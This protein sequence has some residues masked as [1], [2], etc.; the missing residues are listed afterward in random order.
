MSFLYTLRVASA[1][2]VI[3][4]MPGG[5]AS[6][7]CEAVIIMEMPRSFM[8]NRSHK[9]ELIA[10]A[11]R[12]IEFFLQKS[13]IISMSYSTPVEVSCMFTS[14]AVYVAPSYL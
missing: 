1:D 10:S 11:T 13:A 2:S 9:N 7:F 12:R 5:Q 3:I 8:L 4:D 14:S 6:A